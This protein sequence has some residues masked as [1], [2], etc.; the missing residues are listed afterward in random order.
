[1]LFLDYAGRKLDKGPTA[2]RLA[3]IQPDLLLAF[4]YKDMLCSFL[5]CL[6]R[7]GH[8]RGARPDDRHIN[9]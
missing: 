6:D 4:Q 7:S 8:S 1:M 3:D 5:L 2:L 9:I